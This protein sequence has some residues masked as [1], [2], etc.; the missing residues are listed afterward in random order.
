MKPGRWNRKRINHWIW[1]TVAICSLSLAKA[2][3]WKG[4]FMSTWDGLLEDFKTFQ[5]QLPQGPKR[6]RGKSLYHARSVKCVNH[7]EAVHLW[8][9]TSVSGIYSTY[10]LTDTL[11][12][13][14]TSYP[15]LFHLQSC[16]ASKPY[17]SKT[18][19][20]C[21]SET[22][23]SPQYSISHNSSPYSSP[24]QHLIPPRGY[25]TCSDDAPHQRP[26]SGALQQQRHQSWPSCTGQGGLWAW[27]MPM[28]DIYLLCR[29]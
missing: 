10:S 13:I 7:K 14:S 11:A 2:T 29:A 5:A 12:S 6:R 26:K 22:K 23:T 20:F 24:S 21:T 9:I 25:Q 4:A 28:V 27:S 1:A 15:T 8:W 17:L 18:L 19:P 3:F 16:C